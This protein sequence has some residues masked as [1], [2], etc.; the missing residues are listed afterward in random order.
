MI[1]KT[2]DQ[3]FI[4]W[5]DSTSKQWLVGIIGLAMMITGPI[6]AATFRIPPGVALLS[7]GSVLLYF[8]N[9]SR[10]NATNLTKK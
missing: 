2:Y 6:V 9:A 3:R 5:I 10:G 1:S 8:V 7:L 4:D